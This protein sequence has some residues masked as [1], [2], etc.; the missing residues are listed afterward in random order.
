MGSYSSQ[1]KSWQEPQGFQTNQLSLRSHPH[2][3][4]Q[5]YFFYIIIINKWSMV[6]FHTNTLV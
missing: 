5:N 3:Y 2:D 1:I 6:P 4:G